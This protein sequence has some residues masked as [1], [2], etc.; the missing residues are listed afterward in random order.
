MMNTTKNPKGKCEIPIFI[1]KTKFN[2]LYLM[3]MIVA[4]FTGMNQNCF[5]QE[6]ED[7]VYTSQAGLIK[8]MGQVL[9]REGE[10]TSVPLYYSPN[11][12]LCYYFLNDKV[13]YVYEKYDEVSGADTVFRMDLILAENGNWAQLNEHN[14]LYFNNYYL[15]HTGENGI[16][17][18]GVF[19]SVDY[20]H[21]YEDIIVNAS[22]T[23]GLMLGY[24]IEPGA[25][26][27]DISFYFEGADSTVQDADGN[28]RVYCPLDSVVF[29][30]IYAYQVINNE[31][32][33][34]EVAYFLEND[35]IT[36]DVG[37]YNGSYSLF[38]KIGPLPVPHTRIELYWSTF[39]QGSSNFYAGSTDVFLDVDNNVY[40]A[41]ATSSHTFPNMTGQFSIINCPS[42]VPPACPV[43]DAFIL[44]IAPDRHVLWGSYFGGTSGEA[45]SQISGVSAQV[46]VNSQEFVYVAGVTGSL[47]V[48]MCGSC[49]N[50]PLLNQS[51]PCNTNGT[52]DIFIAKFRGSDGLLDPL[53]S[54]TFSTY[55]G[56]SGH[57]NVQSMTIDA[58]DNVYIAGTVH[59]NS[60]PGAADVFDQVT[61]SG[62]YNQ[63]FG[64]AA[65]D[66]D[67][68]IMKL[69]LDVNNK[70]Y[71]SWCT[72]IG[73]DGGLST[74]EIITALT[75]NANGELYA[76]GRTYSNG[77]TGNIANAP[78]T[79]YAAGYFPLVNPGTSSPYIKYNS[80]GY[81][82]F[83]MKFDSDNAIEW[84]TLYGGTDDEN[85]YISLQSV[86]SIA[87][88][89][90][91]NIFITG[92]TQS[93]TY[94]LFPNFPHFVL[95]NVTDHYDQQY[96]HSD[97]PPPNNTC[98]PG[99][100]TTDAYVG[101]FDSGFELKW[102]TWY[103]GCGNNYGISVVSS[104]CCSNT[105]GTPV[106]YFLG[107]TTSGQAGY[108]PYF[109]TLSRPYSY[110]QS[111][112]NG[113]LYD[114]YVLQF[115]N[116]GAR[117]YATLFGG[118]GSDYSRSLVTDDEGS[119]IIFCGSAFPYGNT[120]LFPFAN[121][122]P[123]THVALYW[124]NITGARA[125]L[126]F[127]AFITNMKDLC[128]PCLRV[129]DEEGN[130]NIGEAVLPV[131]PNPSR[132]YITIPFK[133]AKNISIYNSLGVMVKSFSTSN[134]TIYIGDL[135]AGL[136]LI[137]IQDNAGNMQ[138]VKFIVE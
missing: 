56:G 29:D 137:R 118:S 32:V 4:I 116:T 26:P 45:I 20:T 127:N 132:D 102:S 108:Q 48:P 63:P 123:V 99:G 14:Q 91:E 55:F 59:Q 77:Q 62:A 112:F 96:F 47:D 69:S 23:N 37:T 78:C 50:D 57:E 12:N 88:D 92:C 89:P 97:L 129:A 53:V 120:T 107:V 128:N 1:G 24:R 103:G 72:A 93:S 111:T 101:M 2:K 64:Q 113:L 136:Y 104:K 17:S 134:I 87:V 18:V 122:T 51:S 85:E 22:V 70:D 115:L 39:I 42:P 34:V 131:Y 49:T 35:H 10:V 130:S 25:N 133:E 8:N 84:S 58:N 54:G 52:D 95:S 79:S 44:K 90:D 5:A 7:T 60:Y 119:D 41:G 82:A 40:L 106:I 83:F 94:G 110:N 6:E 75:T 9:D 15:A 43:S 3:A 76:T 13:A 81:D 114:S 21:L 80:G 109:P 117:Q 27:Y 33:P 71:I 73:G 31:E 126:G 19:E 67:A 46:V 16:D 98:T 138:T 86:G 121:P 135:S 11:G 65:D 100:L 125:G 30:S 124:D 61:L 66:Y 68:F 105:F 38:I 36:F 74:Y 28:I